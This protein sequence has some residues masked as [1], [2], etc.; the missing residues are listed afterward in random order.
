MLSA[1]P[2]NVPIESQFKLLSKDSPLN[3]DGKKKMRKIAYAS[4][5][6]SLMYAMVC[7]T[8]ELAY[9]ASL[10]CRFIR[11]QENIIGWL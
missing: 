11:I 10:V 4:A 1:K 6:G 5:V 2:T 9:S 7:S 8:P 3:E